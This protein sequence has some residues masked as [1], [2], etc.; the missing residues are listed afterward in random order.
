MYVKKWGFKVWLIVSN[1]WEHLM[2]LKNFM[3]PLKRY[4]NTNECRGWSA[5]LIQSAAGYWHILFEL[6][7]GKMM[8][9]K[10]CSPL[11]PTDNHWLTPC[12]NQSTMF[13]PLL[14]TECSSSSNVWMHLA[15]TFG[16]MIYGVIQLTHP[17][18]FLSH[19]P[20]ISASPQLSLWQS[21]CH[22]PAP[23]CMHR[24]QQLSQTLPLAH[25]HHC[26]DR[27]CIKKHLTPLI[28][29]DVP[30]IWEFLYCLGDKKQKQNDKDKNRSRRGTEIL[31][32]SF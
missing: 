10:T 24:S 25:L 20:W 27:Y 19:G 3:D 2:K 7:F 9:M 5:V 32:F 30:A 13:M 14:F 11:I 29:N 6:V 28:I 17:L 12:E 18:E 21:Q 4:E 22:I 26:R 31:T 15:V 16:L 23:L 8:T 1:N